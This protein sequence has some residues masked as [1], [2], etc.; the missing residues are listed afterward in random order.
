MWHFVW[1]STHRIVSSGVP[2]MQPHHATAPLMAGWSMCIFPIQ[3]IHL[4]VD[5]HL[6]G[7]HFGAIVNY[8]L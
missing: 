1:A 2:M 5:G 6:G 3:F 7:F 4:S 8:A